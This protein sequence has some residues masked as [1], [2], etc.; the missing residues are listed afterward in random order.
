MG[1]ALSQCRC[2]I[3]ALKTKELEVRRPQISY[4][5][6]ERDEIQ[7]SKEHEYWVDSVASSPV[8]SSG[9][10]QN[11]LAEFGDPEGLYHFVSEQNENPEKKEETNGVK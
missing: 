10:P 1:Q 6:E 4:P 8:K 7:E 3:P 5:Y 9:I 11:R 2:K